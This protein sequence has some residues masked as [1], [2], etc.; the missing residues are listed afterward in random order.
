MT[1]AWI[2]A[3]ATPTPS[4]TAKTAGCESP[5]PSCL[6]F[7]RVGWR[8]YSR[9]CVHKQPSIVSSPSEMRPSG[10]SYSTSWCNLGY[11][12]SSIRRKLALTRITHGH[13]SCFASASY[14]GWIWSMTFCLSGHKSAF[15]CSCEEPDLMCLCCNTR[16]QSGRPRMWWMRPQLREG[17][18][19]LNFARQ[20]Q[21]SHSFREQHSAVC[22]CSWNTKLQPVQWC[23]IR[24][25]QS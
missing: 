11:W 8:S 2:A 1:R 24:T 23:R 19:A 4:N 7:T 9:D 18:C 20:L 16:A 13:T 10:F 3:A 15:C 22:Y 6:P 12:L 25:C 5:S 21:I 14:C 17:G